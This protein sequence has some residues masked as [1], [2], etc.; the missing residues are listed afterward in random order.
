M[1]GSPVTVFSDI[2]AGNFWIFPNPYIG[3]IS[4]RVHTQ[5]VF[6]SFSYTP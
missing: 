4:M 3:T 5:E 6:P 1:D 2:R